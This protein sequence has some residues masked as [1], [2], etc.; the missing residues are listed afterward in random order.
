MPAL[1]ERTLKPGLKSTL[2]KMIGLS[3][4]SLSLIHI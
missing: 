3:A 2:V 1:R 4:I